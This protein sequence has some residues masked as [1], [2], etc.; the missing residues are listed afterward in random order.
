MTERDVYR[1][2]PREALSSDEPAAPPAVPKRATRRRPVYR[3]P[4][5]P[6]EFTDLLGL[7]GF[8]RQLQ[9]CA[10]FF[11]SDY[12]CDEVMAEIIA[13]SGRRTTPFAHRALDRD[14]DPSAVLNEIRMQPGTVWIVDVAAFAGR[15]EGLVRDLVVLAADQKNTGA[16]IRG[17]ARDFHPRV[18]GGFGAIFASALSGEELEVLRSVVRIDQDVLDHMQ[19]A[20]LPNLQAEG[21]S[22]ARESRE[23][24]RGPIFVALNYARLPVTAPRL[25][26]NPTVLSPRPLDTQRIL[27]GLQI[28]YPGVVHMSN[29]NVGTASN[30]PMG[31]INSP[32]SNI[33]STAVTAAADAAS[34][35]ALER[36]AAAVEQSGELEPAKKGEYLDVLRLIAEQAGSEGGNPAY[37]RMLLDGLEREL[38]EVGDVAPVAEKAFPALANLKK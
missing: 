37:R 10:I 21:H 27:R 3:R 13:C 14:S 29:Y 7:D 20:M 5:A 23:R 31:N 16:W 11:Q 32:M 18:L 35:E 8:A 17:F 19:L 24:H 15:R 1:P 26:Q 25:V 2:A 30:S 28:M 34:R 22:P 4:Y 9:R 12:A 38:N 33:G 6:R 36:L